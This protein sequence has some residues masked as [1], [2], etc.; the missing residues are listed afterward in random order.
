MAQLMRIKLKHIAR[1]RDRHGVLRHYLRVPGQKAV[2]LPGDPDS[3]A[4]LSAYQAALAVHDKPGP[5]AAKPPREG[6]LNAVAASYYASPAFHSLRATTQVNYRRIVERLRNKHGEKSVA[7]LDSKGVEMLLAERLGHPAA[8]NH[9]LRSIRALMKEATRMKVRTTD[10]TIGVE[11]TKRETKG[12]RAW[13]DQEIAQYEEHWPSG[14]KARLALALLL[15]TGQRRS[16][17]VRMGRQH[18]DG[19]VLTVRQVK[20]GT[21]VVLPILPEL[22][23]ELAHVPAG[24]MTFLARESGHAH[25]AGGFYNLFVSWCAQAGLEPGLAPHGLRKATARRIAERGGTVHQIMSVTGHKTLSEVQVYTAAADQKRLAIRGAA[26]IAKL[27]KRA[28]K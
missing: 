7:L 2:P 4:F 8:Q 22:R 23:Q 5:S 3:P 19:S 13:T 28:R 15:Y 1:F 21:T 26:L 9:L 6:T 14:T 12:Y 17:V 18:V 10:P 20:T 16:D 25:T 11:R 27:P 24:Q